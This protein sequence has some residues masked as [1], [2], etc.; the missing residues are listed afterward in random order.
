MA[1]LAFIGDI[2]LND[3]YIHLK[4]KGVNPFNSVAQHLAAADLVV[5]NLE[6]VLKGNQGENLLKRPRIST[7]PDTLQYLKNINLGMSSLATNHIYDNLEDGFQKTTEFLDKNHIAFLGAGISKDTARAC[8]TMTIKDISFCFLNYITADTNPSLPDN[9][10]IS[11]NEFREEAC[12][13]DLRNA[14]GYDYRI[15]LMHWGGRFEGG[16]FPDYSQIELG[17][18]LIDHGADLIIGHHSHTLQPFERYNGKHI[19]YS[20]G[21]FCFS[22]IQFEGKVRKMTSLRERESVIVRVKF[23][24]AGYNVTLFPFRNE[25]LILHERKIVRT[26][27]YFRNLCWRLMK[28]RGCWLIYKGWFR[29]IRPVIVQLGR[30]DADKSLIRRILGRL[31][32]RT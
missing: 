12:F 22:D 21:N 20:L 17:R 5:G 14:A 26:K 30:K 7:T 15:V 2:G 29:H 10:H 31:S 1:D 13:A 6:C 18:K 23:N 4:N 11:I 16:L 24:K 19:F 9:A 8:V 28:M 3:G 32:Y 25:K 27:L